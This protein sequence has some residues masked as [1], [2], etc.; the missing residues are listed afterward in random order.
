ME[1]KDIPDI[2][3]RSSSLRC[4]SVRPTNVKGWNTPN[5]TCKVSCW[6]PDFLSLSV[7]AVGA[8]RVSIPRIYLSF[9]WN[10]CQRPSC[11]LL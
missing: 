10:T 6:S 11:D 7:S 1:E 8:Y 9:S 2:M 4:A 3:E 5:R